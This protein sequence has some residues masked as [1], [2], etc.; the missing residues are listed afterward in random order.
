[1]EGSTDVKVGP[2]TVP[3]FGLGCMGM[4]APGRSD[5]ASTRTLRRAHEAGVRMFDTADKYGKGHNEVL[6]GRAMADLRD[7]IFL[8]T[9][10]G[11]V[12]SPGDERPVDGRPSYVRQACDRSLERL[13]VDHVDL[14]YL[15][16]VDPQVPIEETVGAMGDLVAA[17][18]VRAIGLSEVSVSTLERAHGVHP[19]AAIQ[20]EYSLW[21]RDVERDVLPYCREH[22]I[23]FVAYSPLGIG[24]LTGRYRDADALP[25]G[26]RLR[27]GP[28]MAE[29]NLARNLGVLEQFEAIA[30]ELGVTP[31]QL[32]LAWVLDQPGTVAIPGAST[33]NHLEENLRAIDVDV[34]DAVRERLAT[35]FDPV[36]IAGARKSEAGL[37]LVR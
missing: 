25:A 29:D 24:F 19:I 33:E 1:M 12:G 21:T 6:V 15:H 2:T 34:D 8:A 28:R 23:A 32:A 18:K 14:L 37:A 16:R 26:N 22:G 10:F 9:K 35:L 7:E 13:G 36:R 30:G 27:R 11:F 17:G 4:S 20:S 31:A 5:E 3:A